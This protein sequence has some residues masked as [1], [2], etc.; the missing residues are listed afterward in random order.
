MQ[1]Y[2][3]AR[4]ASGKWHKII[5]VACISQSQF[6]INA[7]IE[8]F[9]A[10]LPGLVGN[11]AHLVVNR[12]SVLNDGTDFMYYNGPGTSAPNT[13]NSNGHFVQAE[14]ILAGMETIRWG[15]GF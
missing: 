6:A 12:P 13:L 7:V 10:L 4:V 2:L 8:A 1:T 15:T 9:N 11:R 3:T 14:A 5:V